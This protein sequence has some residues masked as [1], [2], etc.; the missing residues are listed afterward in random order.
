MQRQPK[1]KKKKKN[2]NR[3]CSETKYKNLLSVWN[4]KTYDAMK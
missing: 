1:K 3:L 4:L 2:Q